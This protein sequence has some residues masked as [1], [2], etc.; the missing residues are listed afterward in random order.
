MILPIIGAIAVGTGTGST[1][2]GAIATVAQ[3][4]TAETG[5]AVG[6]LI[7]ASIGTIVGIAENEDE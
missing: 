6:A 4:A 5:A 1:L 2:G 7:G 3:I